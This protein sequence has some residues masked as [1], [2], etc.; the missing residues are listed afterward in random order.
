MDYLCSCL[1]RHIC[2][3]FDL[4]ALHLASVRDALIYFSAC[5]PLFVTIQQLSASFYRKLISDYKRKEEERCLR[6][7]TDTK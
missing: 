2:E 1:C 7:Q 5:F 4:R 6:V 3:G